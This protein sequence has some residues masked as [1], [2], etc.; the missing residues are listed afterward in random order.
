[1]QDWARPRELPSLAM[2]QPTIEQRAGSG[3][4]SAMECFASQPALWPMRAAA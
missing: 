4:Q 2:S 1:M 3:V